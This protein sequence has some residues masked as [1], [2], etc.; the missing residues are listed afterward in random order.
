MIINT[1]QFLQG[2]TMAT[3]NEINKIVVQKECVIIGVTITNTHKNNVYIPSANR[4]W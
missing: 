4:L 1:Q 3:L 2:Q